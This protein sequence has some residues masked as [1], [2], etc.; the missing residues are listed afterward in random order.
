VDL[1]SGRCGEWAALVAPA[2]RELCREL[3][4]GRSIRERCPRILRDDQRSFVGVMEGAGGSIVAKSPRERDRRRWN[5]LTSLAGESLPFRTLRAIAALEAA[6]VPTPA[7]LLALERRRGGVVVE[8]WLF[9][10][11]LEGTPCT[12]ADVPE[13]IALLDRMH[14][15]GWVHGDAHIQNFIRTDS[16]IAILDPGPNRPRFGRVSAAYDLILLRN[17]RPEVGTAFARAM[18]DAR[19]DAA[20]RIA[21]AW[22]D[23]IHLWR[24]SKRAVRDLF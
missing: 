24:R 13:I 7:G 12:A 6:G 9:T 10:R 3:G 4:D 5:R 20:F 2:G 14:R 16:G 19:R 8:S 11:W 22:D 1:E 23:W 21:A 18:P 15:A 17:S